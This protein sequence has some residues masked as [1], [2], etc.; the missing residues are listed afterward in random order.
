MRRMEKTFENVKDNG[1]EY[2]LILRSG[3]VEIWREAELNRAQA[4]G[5]LIDAVLR[6]D[7]NF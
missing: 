5:D 6:E 1:H 7:V 4:D 3:R 2:A